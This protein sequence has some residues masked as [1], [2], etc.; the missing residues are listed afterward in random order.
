[1]VKF[2]LLLL[3]VACSSCAFHTGMISPGVQ[4]HQ[5]QKLADIAVGYSKASYFLGLGGLKKDAL[6]NDAK[7]K[8]YLSSKLKPGQALE[9]IT[10]NIKTT[11]IG[12]YRKREVIVVADVTEGDSLYGM[13]FSK[14]Y[15]DMISAIKK[16]PGNFFLLN[17]KILFL[18][19]TTLGHGKIIDYNSRNARVFYINSSGSLQVKKM[20]LSNIFKKDSI[21][22]SQQTYGYSI[23][24]K[25]S[26]EIKQNNQPVVSMKS[27][28]IGLNETHALLSA[29]VKVKYRE[30]KK[31]N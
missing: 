16:K 26:V 21:A 18:Q 6:V 9:N 10:L 23:G 28:I 1:M 3:V 5:K 4:Y 8:L 24:D 2:L 17:D 29:L 12:P 27:T 25:V 31:V 7:Y 19:K 30:L 11:C 13:S 15:I 14:E 22:V 20:P